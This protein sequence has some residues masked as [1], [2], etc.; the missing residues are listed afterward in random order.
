MQTKLHWNPFEQINVVGLTKF[1]FVH[2]CVVENSK[3]SRFEE[4]DY[5]NPYNIKSPNFACIRISCSVAC[6]N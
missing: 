4:I 2:Y 3:K 5:K 6:T 1:I